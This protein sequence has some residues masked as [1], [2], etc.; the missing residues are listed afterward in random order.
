MYLPKIRE[1]KEALTSLF[2]KPYT[3]K[4]PAGKYIP[5]EEYR[6]KPRF[7]PEYCVGC[8][9]CAQVC[10]PGA[11]T[12]SDSITDKTRALK[13]SYYS[14]INCGQCEENC[15]TGQGV[16]LTNEYSFAVFTKDAPEMFESVSKD[17]VL[18]ELCGDI[19]ASTDHL[20][21]IMNRMGAKAFAHPNML[22][23]LQR[24][25]I[26][27]EPPVLKSRIRREDQLM[28][29]CPKCRHKIVIEDEF[30]MNH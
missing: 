1:L 28:E 20:K 13:I 24:E 5:S 14:C 3:S 30:Y 23:Q 16:K 22:L 10:P 15:I 25:F 6:G 27:V 12:V 18:C 7:N 4:F 19:I 11:I 17:L 21:W 9:T 8:G 29:V 2:T 26:P